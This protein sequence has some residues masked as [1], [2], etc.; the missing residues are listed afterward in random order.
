MQ[1][2]LDDQKRIQEQ[3]LQQVLQQVEAKTAEARETS[4][5]AKRIASQCHELEMKAKAQFDG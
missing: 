5:M 4:A 2:A 3:K 1:N